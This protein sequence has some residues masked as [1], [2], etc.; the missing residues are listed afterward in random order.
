MSSVTFHLAATSD[1]QTKLA[2]IKRETEIKNIWRSIMQLYSL[3]TFFPSWK[4]FRH[5]FYRP[6]SL[7]PAALVGWV[8]S[9][10][11]FK[12]QLHKSFKKSRNLRHSRYSAQQEGFFRGWIFIL[13]LTESWNVSARTQWLPLSY[14]TFMH[15][16]SKIYRKYSG[17]GVQL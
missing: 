3:Y 9:E 6:V 5:R 8:H 7:A 12:E 10:L 15:I 1:V 11:L 4:R 13:H 16:W 14:L 2:Q 17:G